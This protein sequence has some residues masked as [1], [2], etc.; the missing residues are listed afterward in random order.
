VYV[1][2]TLEDAGPGSFRDAVSKRHRIVVFAVGGVIKLQ[3]DVAV[4]SDITIAGQSAAGE[5]I[6]LYGRTVSLSGQG[7]VIIRYMRFREGIAG[8][9]GKCSINAAKT[10]DIILDH[11]SI[12]WGRWDCLGLTE[13]TGEV[14]VQYC[15]IG[16][17]VDPQRFGSIIDSATNVTLSH[18]LWIHNESR[19][20]KCKGTIQDINNVIYDWGV[21]GLAG[22]HSGA[23]HELDAINNYLIKGRS[24]NDH[25][26]GEY[27][28]TDQVY[29]TGNFVDLDRDGQLNGRLMTE[30]DFADAKGAPTFLQQPSLK[31]PV[32]VTVDSA[33]EAYQKVVASA[34]AS[35]HRDAVDRR[36]IDDVRSLGAKGAIS[37]SEADVG[38]QGEL[39]GGPVEKSTLEDGISDQWKYAHHLD[40]KDANLYKTTAPTGFADPD[41]AE[42]GSRSSGYTYLEVY[43]NE[44]AMNRDG[45]Q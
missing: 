6:C 31:P 9:K 36:L 37:K 35:L 11:C 40:P 1:V 39:A 45:L 27:T 3:S 14:T 4:S 5:G 23:K 21:T 15:I 10:H 8:S 32:G 12:E 19:N 7:N 18:D 24:S 38:G 42:N 13:G 2:T 26:A 25:A 17:G 20:P 30:K 22:G 41:N 33:Q 44:L 29:Q 34:G 43:L 16:E 28:A